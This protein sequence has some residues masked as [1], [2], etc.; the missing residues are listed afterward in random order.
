MGMADDQEQIYDELNDMLAYFEELLPAASSPPSTRSALQPGATVVTSEPEPV[1]SPSASPEEPAGPTSALM[2]ALE[3]SLGEPT[4]FDSGIPWAWKSLRRDPLTT[5]ELAELPEP[6][7]VLTRSSSLEE[8]DLFLD[9]VEREVVRVAPGDPG[10]SQAYRRLLQ[11][12]PTNT[13][14]EAIR[15]LLDSGRTPKEVRL[16]SRIRHR[17]SAIFVEFKRYD[18]WGPRFS[19]SS[20][21]TVSWKLADKLRLAGFHSRLELFR[22]FRQLA[23]RFESSI[24]LRQQFHSVV[25]YA[26]VLLSSRQPLG[27]LSRDA[28]PVPSLQSRLAELGIGQCWIW[29]DPA[30][31]RLSRLGLPVRSELLY[32]VR[33]ARGPSTPFVPYR[34]SKLPAVSAEEDQLDIEALV[35]LVLVEGPLSVPCLLQRCETWTGSKDR[36]RK[37]V[38]VICEG[39]KVVCVGSDL[40]YYRDFPPRPGRLPRRPLLADDLTLE[41]ATDFDLGLGFQALRRMYPAWTTEHLEDAFLAMWKADH[42]SWLRLQA[43]LRRYQENYSKV[44]LSP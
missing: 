12:Y 25:N 24:Q 14:R 28:Q 27:Q 16:N 30:A 33:D 34:T 38:A 42:Q 8:D 19:G 32:H 39:E 23:D 15:R 5:W 35:R 1:Q 41:L 2:T 36:A 22:F 6:A 9:K 43:A 17:C 40:W 21:H 10:E 18:L 31:T 4:F 13:S 7:T 11:D 29:Q 44:G 20:N 3:P 37:L 26:E